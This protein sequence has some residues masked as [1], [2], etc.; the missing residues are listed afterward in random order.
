MG[1]RKGLGF[2]LKEWVKGRDWVV[3]GRNERKKGI[4]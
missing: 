1:E 4:G 3:K 2:G